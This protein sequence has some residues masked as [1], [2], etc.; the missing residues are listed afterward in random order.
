MSIS[1]IENKIKSLQRDIERLGKE[2]ESEA[3]REASYYNSIARTKRSIT[4][5]TSL[6]TLKT[7]ERSINNDADKINKSSKK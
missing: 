1:Q 4:K 2:L 6:S 3:K 7:K 5:N